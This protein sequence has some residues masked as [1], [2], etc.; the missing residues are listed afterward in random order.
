[1]PIAVWT[2]TDEQVVRRVLAGR[3]NDFGILVRRHL[4]AVLAVA[5]GHLAG[6]ADVDDVAQESFL[7]AY[8]K[9]DTLRA[10]EKFVSWLLMIAR[11]TALNWQ[12]RQGR[13]VPLDESV[14][15]TLYR[16]ETPP[17]RKEMQQMLHQTLMELPADTREVLLM[18]YYGGCSL[19][20]IAQ[21]TGIS[22]DAAAKRLQRAREALGAEFLKLVPEARTSS[23][24]KR[25]AKT[26]AAAVIAAGAA[27]RVVPAYGAIAGVVIGAAK[28]AGVAAGILALM[29]GAF[30]A[31]PSVL[32]W[33]PIFVAKAGLPVQAVQSGKIPE[34]AIPTAKETASAKEGNSPIPP[35][36][37]SF[38]GTLVTPL[39]GRVGG[40]K[41]TVERVTW[42]AT[43][44]PPSPTEQ[45][46]VTANPYGS[47]TVDGLPPGVY[48]MTAATRFLGGAGRMV[49]GQDRETCNSHEIKMY[50]MMRAYG[51]LVDTRGKGVAGAVI[52]PVA[53]AFFPGK[54]FDH[55]EVSGLRALTDDQGRFQ[56]RQLL[57]GAWKY[58]VACPDHPPFYTDFIP[59]YGLRSTIVMPDPILLTARVLDAAGQPVA[60]L[61]GSVHAGPLQ[62]DSK[63]RPAY[64]IEFPFTS[65]EKGAFTVTTMSPG[66]WT[67]SMNDAQL[68]LKEPQNSVQIDGRGPI[69][70]ELAVVRGGVLSGRLLNKKTGAPFPGM[71][72][73]LGARGDVLDKERITTTDPDGAYV[74]SGLPDG[75]F[76][77]SYTRAVTGLAYGTDP[78]GDIH[79]AAGTTVANHDVLIYP[80]FMLTGRVLDGSGKP[81]SARVLA[82]GEGHH[83]ETTSDDTGVFT[84]GLR[85]PAS[86]DSTL[87]PTVAGEEVTLVASTGKA[88]SP[89][90]LVNL[91]ALNGKEV[92]LHVTEAA[93]GSVEGIV[94]DREDRPVCATRIYPWREDGAAM[95][96]LGDGSRPFTDSN[97]RFLITGLAPGR[98]A[99]HIEFPGEPFPMNPFTVEVAKG[100]VTRGV[101]IKNAPR[102]SLTIEGTLY[103]AN[104]LPASMA[105]L[106]LGDGQTTS[107]GPL[108]GF[109]FKGLTEGRTTLFVAYPG[110]SPLIVT[111]IAAGT[112]GLRLFFKKNA[113]MT[114]AVTDAQTGLP[115]TNFTVG[116]GTVVLPRFNMDGVWKGSQAVS[117]AQGHFRI[118]TVPAL[119]LRVSVV[120]PGYARW[121]RDYPEPE[122]GGE[123][124]VTAE[125][126]RTPVTTEDMLRN[127]AAEEDSEPYGPVENPAYKAWRENARLLSGLRVTYAYKKT[128]TDAFLDAHTGKEITGEAAFIIKAI[129]ARTE[130]AL[131]VSRLG[132]SLNR[133]RV[134]ERFEEDIK[135]WKYA[136]RGEN[137]YPERPDT[138]NS[139]REVFGKGVY[140]HYFPERCMGSVWPKWDRRP[141]YPVTDV[142]P[143]D[144]E[145]TKLTSVGE[146]G[147]DL[148]FVTE[149][150][151]LLTRYFLDPAQ[152]MM[153]IRIE[154]YNVPADK[155]A[156]WFLFRFFTVEEYMHTERGA[157]LPRKSTVHD[158]ARKREDGSI[159]VDK[160]YAYDMTAYE[161]NVQFAPDEFVLHFPQGTFVTDNMVNK[162]YTV[163]AAGS[164]E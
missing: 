90:T 142:L 12:R 2:R 162:H 8:Q 122:S 6:T 52:Y 140:Y 134:L 66:K 141:D 26:I 54:E 41:V 28:C 98:Y 79:V 65:D 35:G 123:V 108:G 101:V 100:A 5:R 156:E 29:T 135:E 59:C 88:W 70:H 99:L 145:A 36:A 93:G 33:Q 16:D 128:P 78:A 147:N 74:F 138:A 89:E 107:A 72:L 113:F 85:E 116:F 125:L 161:E 91:T 20:E 49:V 102:G 130:G 53:N 63:E 60:H 137:I 81:V 19:R 69:E 31:A 75:D 23:E 18:H 57:P 150:S 3:Q 47:F 92:V 10:P 96:P 94:L 158:L 115:V 103:G 84:L 131:R 164:Q 67:F 163:G 157:W 22:R 146:S 153:P 112:R 127:D 129:L 111:D 120:A 154:Y 77:I 151:T 62:S 7:A 83:S 119:P 155:D 71:E 159:S 43:E 160:I 104:H 73:R 11:N 14:A 13:E 56:F 1:M 106:G 144:P 15:Q 45:W 126:Q 40:G 152:G 80:T 64:R 61:A 136:P 133:K 118:D 149:N 105:V 30:F 76:Y 148:D 114:G 27:W 50:P 4:P 21:A 25:H 95:P 68:T 86:S 42:D 109:E 97:G 24:L 44:L 46:T 32:G 48:S 34:D 9:L 37:F 55:V 143:P 39:S 51:I 17:D 117:D 87:G 132:E 139:C 121:T 38:S 58:F 124:V 110:C 82:K